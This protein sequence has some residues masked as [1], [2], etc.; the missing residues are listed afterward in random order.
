MSNTEA[1]APNQPDPFGTVNVNQFQVIVD[2]ND[3][4]PNHPLAQRQ[5]QRYIDKRV[6]KPKGV[7][8]NELWW[9][10][11]T[12]LMR[13]INSFE[14]LTL[15]RV[16]FLA[17]H[18]GP[19]MVGVHITG[20]Q[21]LSLGRWEAGIGVLQE[22]SQLFTNSSAVALYRETARKYN[23]MTGDGEGTLSSLARLL[24]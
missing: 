14:K 19:G 7:S 18:D 6:E 2:L 11:Y 10:I 23:L 16:G 12:E 4:M 15:R 13:S 8:Y 22:Q 3:Y 21:E 5:I 20:D 9:L 1:V 17:Q 24:I